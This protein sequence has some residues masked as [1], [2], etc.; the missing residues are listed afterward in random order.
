MNHS[1]QLIYSETSNYAPL[2]SSLLDKIQCATVVHRYVLTQIVEKLSALEQQLFDLC[3]RTAFFWNRA[4]NPTT[5]LANQN[6]CDAVVSNYLPKLA[7]KYIE[8][9][10]SALRNNDGY[11][12]GEIVLDYD[13]L[14]VK[15]LNQHKFCE[16]FIED[17]KNYQ[18]SII[19]LKSKIN[20]EIVSQFNVLRERSTI[21]SW[22]IFKVYLKINSNANHNYSHRDDSHSEEIIKSTISN[23]LVGMNQ[24]DGIINKTKNLQAQFKKTQSINFE[25]REEIDKNHILALIERVIAVNNKLEKKLKEKK[26]KSKRAL[27]DL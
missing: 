11:T 14:L 16:V 17:I 23:L 12:F 20:D 9:K 24:T 5:A 22:K 21:L 2:V 8:E 27:S 3:R 26:A 25:T 1:D 10:N 13:R 19:N 4:D 6:L 15:C 18:M 7:T